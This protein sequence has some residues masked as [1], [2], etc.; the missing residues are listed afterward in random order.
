MKLINICA[1]IALSGLF[2][3]AC[4]ATGMFCPVYTGND[5]EKLKEMKDCQAA[6]AKRAAEFKGLVD[7]SA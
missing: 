5:P 1:V 3:L 7:V 4:L 2:S 6:Q